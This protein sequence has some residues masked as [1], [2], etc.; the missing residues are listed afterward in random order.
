MVIRE[1]VFSIKDFFSETPIVNFK[2][3]I[4]ENLPFCRWGL[5]LERP[6][7]GLEARD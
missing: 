1:I 4:K 7:F 2:F 6:V 5:A 3:L